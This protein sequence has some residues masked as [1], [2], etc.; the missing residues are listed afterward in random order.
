MVAARIQRQQAGQR[1]RY[2]DTTPAALAASAVR[3]LASDPTW[4]PIRCDGARRAAELINALLP[5]PQRGT[6]SPAQFVLD[7]GDVGG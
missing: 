7:Q 6:A 3:L 5:S 4:P 1:L 2:A